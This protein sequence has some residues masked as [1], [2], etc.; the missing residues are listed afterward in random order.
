MKKL[1]AI[2]A[3]IPLV[4]LFIFGL[5]GITIITKGLGLVILLIPILAFWGFNVLSEEQ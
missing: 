5:V 3:I 4:L 2:L 1:L